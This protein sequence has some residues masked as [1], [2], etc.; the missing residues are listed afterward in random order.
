MSTRDTLFP[1][2]LKEG[3]WLQFPAA[4]YSK[5]VCGFLRRRANPPTFGMPLGSIDTGCL[6]VNPDSTLGLCSIFNSYVPMRGPL[7]LPF[8]G[9]TVGKITWVLS[10]IPFISNENLYYQN[11]ATPT[12]IHYWG[13]YP[14]VDME[15]EM[16][17]SPVSV[18]VR[19]WSPFIVGDAAAS[20]T[21][22]AVFQVHLRNSSAE[23]QAGQLV[24]S[25][26]G[27]T[28]DQFTGAMSVFDFDGALFRDLYGSHTR[29][30]FL[31]YMRFHVSDHRPLWVE[32]KT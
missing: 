8:L 14:V 24:M 6:G 13:H 30:Q 10:T 16:P 18:G 26:P 1:V 4:G 5:P 2:E 17:G 29:T 3:E 11:L 31:A 7:K 20:N 25:F 19:G 27:P 22:A 9:I 21:P 28:Q 32:F 23:A 15:Y 12:D